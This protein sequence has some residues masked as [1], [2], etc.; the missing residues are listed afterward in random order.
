[1]TAVFSAPEGDAI[2][3]PA[4]Y[5][6]AMMVRSRILNLGQIRSPGPDPEGPLAR[7]V[8]LRFQTHLPRQ[9]G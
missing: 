8:T 9:R 3:L 4:R 7:R 6:V 1:M 5:C 2:V